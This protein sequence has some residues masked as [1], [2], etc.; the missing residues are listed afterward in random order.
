M[1]RFAVFLAVVSFLSCHSAQKAAYNRAP[2]VEIK[3]GGCFGFCPVVHLKVRNSGLVEYEGIRYAERLGVDSFQLTKAELSELRAAVSQTNLW[4][5]PDRIE[6][7]VADAPFVTLTAYKDDQVKSVNGSIDRPKPLLDLENKLKQLADAHGFQFDRGVNPN[8]I[9]EN[10]R[11]E[12]IVKLSPETNAGNWVRQ[13]TEFRFQLIRRLGAENIW[14]V[15]Y[16]PKQIDEKAVIQLF[17][18]SRGVLEVQ[19]K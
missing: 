6:T 10:R 12:L 8:D 15:A 17:K 5:Y 11:L 1:L 19:P 2:F 4:Q 18:N 3:T 14:L 9:P 13:F 16:D 7:Q